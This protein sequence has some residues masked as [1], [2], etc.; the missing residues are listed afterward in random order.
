MHL[1]HYK[2]PFLFSLVCAVVS[3]GLTPIAAQA[4]E[5]ELILPVSDSKETSL[6]DNPTFNKVVGGALLGA[7]LSCYIRL[8][9]KKTQPKRV[10]PET[11]SFVD[12]SW[13]VFDELL[14][15]QMEKGERASKV[16]ISEENPY[17]LKIEYS[18]I[19]ARGLTGIIY[20]SMKPIIIPA[21]TLLVLFNKEFKEK[22]NE[23]VLNMREF[24]KDPFKTLNE[25]VLAL[26]G[27][28]PVAKKS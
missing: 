11:D 22:V 21:L 1:V 26:R 6:T 10:Y 9:T 17:E 24:I 27:E 2:K 18:K 25:V 8:I 4:K 23:G 13:F 7:I 5:T 28:L 16:V 19:E 12:Y 14:V 15:G 20:S 3:S